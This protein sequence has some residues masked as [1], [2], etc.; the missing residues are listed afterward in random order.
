M[1]MSNTTST[2]G[3]LW[4]GV[5]LKLDNASFHFEGMGEALQPPERTAYAAVLESS[6]TLFWGNWHR[7][8]YAHLD[9]FL[10]T[11]RSVP[12]LVRC[13]F[14]VDDGHKKM[15]DWFEALDPDEQKRRRE[16]RDK[17]KADYDAFRAL[18][19]GTARHISEHRTGVPPVTVTVTGRFG[20]T[21][22]GGPTKPIPTSE[23][24]EMPPE[25]GWMQKPMPVR[26]M[27]TDFNI[28]G[29]PLF[30]ACRDYLDSA[31]ALVG[32]ARALGEK[33]HGNS[34]LIPPPDE[35]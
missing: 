32:R 35:M 29:K 33:V 15:R 5:D 34:K 12:E 6:G 22:S 16:F 7:A 19:L 24:R 1:P 3:D 4:A 27:W 10:S 9:A 13:C 18:P 23:A 28:D 8:F 17:F 14:G 2:H 30:E 21:Y 20:L 11:A 25:L 26:P 31:R